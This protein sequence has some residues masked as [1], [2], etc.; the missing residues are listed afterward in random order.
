[1]C[2]NLLELDLSFQFIGKIENLERLVKLRD[3]NLAEN[4]IKKLENLHNLHELQSL[5]LSGNHISEI[6]KLAIEPLRN[7]RI[8]RLSKNK[9]TK[10]EEFANLSVLSNLE[11]LN[12]NGNQALNQPDSHLHLLYFLPSLLILDGSTVS[13]ANKQ[14]AQRMFVGPPPEA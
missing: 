14:Q 5:N 2:V 3:L 4:N 13:L 10:L 6:P 1:M 11:D 12:L 8:F 9:I 7:L